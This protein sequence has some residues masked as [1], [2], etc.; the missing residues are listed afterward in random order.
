MKQSQNARRQPLLITITTVGTV[1][2][3]IFDDIYFYAC[4]V[5]DGAIQDDTF[6]PVIYELDSREEWQDPTKWQK[7]NPG[8][9]LCRPGY[10]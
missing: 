4:S 1:R 2:E 6:L 10:P 8:R 9:T 5:A 3:C 7:A